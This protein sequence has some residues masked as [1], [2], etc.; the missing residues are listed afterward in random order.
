MPVIKDVPFSI[1]AEKLL[2]AQKRRKPHPVLL[3]AAEEAVSLARKLVA[4]AGIYDEFDVHRVGDGRVELSAGGAVLHVGPKVDLL[5]PAR[6]VFVAVYTIGPALEE[7]V[8]ELYD[9]DETLLGYMLDSVGVMAL[10]TVGERLQRIAEEHAAGRGWGVSPPLAP[11]SLVGWPVDG[12]R[13]LCALLPIEEIGVRL[14]EYCVLEP[15]K[16]ASMVM[17]MG[18]DYEDHRLRPI[19]EFCALRDTCW[20]RK[21]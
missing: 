4:P 17:G 9:C 7:K 8:A 18:P 1:T 13:E 19:C 21:T 3:R 6:Q 15:H 14:N 11:G 10:G 12:Q 2:K 16:S 5:A 20:R